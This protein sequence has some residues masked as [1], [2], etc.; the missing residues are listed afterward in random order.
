MIDRRDL[1]SDLYRPRVLFEISFQLGKEVAHAIPVPDQLGWL[2]S[3]PL[4]LFPFSVVAVAY[5]IGY[6]IVFQALVLGE[7]V[8]VLLERFW[9]KFLRERWIDVVPETVQQGVR[10]VWPIDGR[11]EEY[12]IERENEYEAQQYEEELEQRGSAELNEVRGQDNESS[13]RR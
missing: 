4:I 1:E 5:A 8:F 3:A 10:D 7:R 12:L 6:V 9:Y 2:L 13:F 11:F